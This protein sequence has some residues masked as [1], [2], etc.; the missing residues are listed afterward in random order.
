M[1]MALKLALLVMSILLFSKTILFRSESKEPQSFFF[2]DEVMHVYLTWKNDTSRTITVNIHSTLED[3]D[4]VYD[5]NSNEELSYR[6]HVQ[7][8]G[9][10]FEE[11][12]R[13]IHHIELTDLK[14]GT[15]YYF[16]IADKFKPLT[17]EKKFR[18]IEENSSSYLF[19]Q[20]GDWELTEKGQK[21]A[22][23]ASKMDPV[24]V[25]LGGD[26]PKGVESLSDYPKWDKW[27][28]V[29]TKN[30]ITTEGC[31]IPLVLA[32]GNHEVVGSF[33]QTPDKALF[34]Y[35]YFPQN[36]SGKSYFS[37]GFGKNIRLFVLDSAHSESYDGLQKQ[38]LEEDL[39]AY[40]T[41]PVKWAMYHVPIYPSVRFQ[42]DHFLYRMIAA[43]TRSIGYRDVGVKLISPY[44][45]RGL[46]HWAPLF[47]KYA[48][49][50][51]FEHHDQAL[52]RTY[53]LKGG[54]IDPNGVVYLGD[55]GWGP[56]QHTP[57]QKYTSSYLEKSLSHVPFFWLLEVTGTEVH[58][59]AVS[60]S[61]Y[62][63]DSF[64]Q[65][66]PQKN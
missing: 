56:Q 51:A 45:E 39:Q 23:L 58:Y 24:C 53:P 44:S 30:M 10:F 54:G 43:A 33:D 27:L 13:Y 1:K 55:G 42:K 7:N 22:Q 32:I 19:V 3:L 47:D 38:W 61:G 34:Y 15:L 49:T 57:L 36:D 66:L 4:L 65:V 9:V 21:L 52:K 50:A 2:Q 8:K 60:D 17:A 25:L 5:E 14:P 12:N 16:K 37:K 28:D 11:A 63:I 59:Q 41:I 20:G 35:R 31:L 62:V 18:T 29:Y 6:C 40:S 48:I 64:H 26:Y 46:K